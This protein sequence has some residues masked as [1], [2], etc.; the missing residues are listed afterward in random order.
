MMVA[1][2]PE[3]ANEK[4]AGQAGDVLQPLEWLGQQLPA[5]AQKDE[6]L[7]RAQAT[8]E[9]LRES[10]RDPVLLDLAVL[11]SA[12]TTIDL[13]DVESAFGVELARLLQSVR[14]LDRLGAIEAKANARREANHVEALRRMTLAMAVDIRVILLR[15]ADRV[16]ALREFA[17]LAL[18]PPVELAR[19][20]LE[21]LAPLANR[22]GLW[23]LKW[24]LEDL[25]FRF[26]EP[27]AYRAIADELEERRADRELFLRAA[28]ERIERELSDAGIRVRV[29]GRPKHIYSIHSKMRS[30]RIPLDRVLDLRAIRIVVADVAACYQAL[31]V[32]HGIWTP[33]AGE[34]DD[35]IARPK[36][37][38][39]QSLHTVVMAEDGRPFEVQIRTAEMHHAAEYGLASHWAYKE[40]SVGVAGSGQAKA[41]DRHKLDWLRQLLAWQHDLGGT[42]GPATAPPVAPDQE[43][44]QRIFVLTP[45]GRVIELPEHATPVDFAYHVHTDLGHRCRG[46][47][48][49]GLMVPLNSSLTNGQTVEVVTA[50]RNAA[51][52]GPSRDWLNQGLGYTRSNRARS[53][54]RQ[55]FNAQQQ[56]QALSLGR[57][58]VERAMQREGRSSLSLEVL[59]S[60]LGLSG[61]DEL[62]LAVARD[63]LGPRALEVGIRN[64]SSAQAA[65]GK[66]EVPVLKRPTVQESRGAVLVVGV[67]LLLT[68]LARCCRPIPPDAIGGFVTRGKGISVH[69]ADCVGFAR[70]AQLAPERVVETTWG[71]PAEPGR[72][73]LF[74][75]EIWVEG[76]DRPHLARDLLD[77]CARD[78][79][80]VTSLTPNSRGQAQRFHLVI[81]VSDAL[82]LN[83]LMTAIRTV[84]GVYSIGRQQPLRRR[85]QSA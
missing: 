57:E 15:L 38:G 58:R 46:A 26:L 23:Q 22:L 66:P 14:Q 62:F 44:A 60:R 33:V 54:V 72:M 76:D 29:S 49:D 81:E 70:L 74:S 40:A 43:S 2:R 11:A 55:W 16:R 28:C 48:V 10:F 65:E 6:L 78:K 77:I 75:A 21:V 67:D 37:N 19:E 59:A 18:D 69:R 47:R 53:K 85:S 83:R 9:I 36:S 42:D 73:R 1:R 50:P 52:P 71:R 63:E 24:E 27:A 79:L 31:T 34:F 32:V 25:S 20:A 13:A 12:G 61:A 56:A 64:E 5:G 68:Q 4:P 8:L 17:R 82:A 39:Y 30:K 7:A 51:H 45:A 35:Y 80:T 3:A 41:S 84:P